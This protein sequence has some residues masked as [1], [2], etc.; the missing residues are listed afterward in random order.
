M[1]LNFK[2]FL[3]DERGAISVDWVVLTAACVAL[4]LLAITMISG[5]IR[6]NGT[7]ASAIMQT[8]EI[9]HEFDTEAEIA[10]LQEAANDALTPDPEPEPVN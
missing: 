7:E 9:N 8:Y 4:G 2:T 3:A 10:A 6:D 5:S 1:A